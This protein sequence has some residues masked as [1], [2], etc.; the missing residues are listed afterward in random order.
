[1]A[2]AGT[3]ASVLRSSV[4]NGTI[5]SCGAGLALAVAALIA[6]PTINPLP[7]DEEMI[8]HFNKHRGEL[9]IL[10]ER[11]R[12]H[13]VSNH[14]VV[15]SELPEI[16]ELRS[17]AG[18][19]R[20]A[21]SGMIWLP[22][23]YSAASARRLKEIATVSGAQYIALNRRHGSLKIELNDRRYGRPAIVRTALASAIWKE[24]VFFPMAPKVEHGRLW[25]PAGLD[26]KSRQS[27]RVLDSLNEYPP[28]WKKGECLFRPI[29]PQWF[30]RMCWG[31]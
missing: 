24:Y 1:M 29:E 25:W 4:G 28:G 9:E 27:D 20:V 14:Q 15:W 22:E 5:W 10:V 19:S 30:I 8:A 13:D 26:G 31:A 12:K 21:E 16:V 3:S 2:R 7:R 11:Y 6:L 17:R 18:V 23:P